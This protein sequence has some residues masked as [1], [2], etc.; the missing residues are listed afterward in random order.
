MSYTSLSE[1]KEMLVFLLPLKA[2]INFPLFMNRLHQFINSMG[3]GYNFLVFY[4]IPNP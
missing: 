3:Q 2:E 4:F 1:V